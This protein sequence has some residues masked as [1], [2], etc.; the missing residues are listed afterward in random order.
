M[1]VCYFAVHKFM[2]LQEMRKSKEMKKLTDREK[3]CM[4]KKKNRVSLSLLCCYLLILLA[5]SLSTVVI[6]NMARN[7]MIDNQKERITS[8]LSQVNNSFNQE[9]KMAQNVGYYVSREKRLVNYLS[10]MKGKNDAQ[11]FYE[12]YTIA[13][14]YPNYSL[15]NQT[16][17]NVY[18]LIADSDYIIRIPQVLPKNEHGAATLEGFP[19]YSYERFQEFYKEQDKNQTLF[20]YEENP[21]QGSLLLP[22]QMVYPGIRDRECAIV[23]E[24]DWSKIVKMMQPVLGG[25]TGMVALLDREG[26]VLESCQIRKNSSQENTL[27]NQNF[28]T[29]RNT[30]DGDKVT[31]FQINCGY[32]GWQLAAAIPNEVLYQR[33]GI[34]RYVSIALCVTAILIGVLICFGYWYRGKGVVE[35]CYSLQER[36]T[37]NVIGGTGFWKNFGIF[38]NQVDH[39]HNTVEKQEQMLK[40]AVLRKVLY[41][42]YKSEEEILESAV[43]VQF[44]LDDKNYSVVTIELEDP[45]QA[46]SDIRINRDTLQE[47]INEMIRNTLPWNIWI[48]RVSELSSVLLVHEKT[49]I[50]REELKNDLNKLNFELHSRLNAKGYIGVSGIAEEIADIPKQYEIASRVCEYARYQGIC[51]PVLPEDMPNEKIIEQPMFFSIDM[52]MKLI[53]LLKSGNV[54]QIEEMIAQI[55]EIYLYQGIDSYIYRHTVEMLRGCLFRSIPTENES[56]KSRELSAAASKAHSAGEIFAMMRKVGAF[57]EEAAKERDESQVCIDK[58]KVSDYIEENYGDPT[59]NLSVLAEWLGEPERRIYND[60]KVCFGMS[61]SSYLEQRRLASACELLKKGAAVKDIAE[62]VGYSSDYSFR[63]AFKRAFGVSPSDFKKCHPTS[64]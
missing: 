36:I 55:K 19:L 23:V 41:G 35:E 14:N 21:G 10:Q 31:Y 44:P 58:Q 29:L 37:Q 64:V 51:V 30:K 52:E 12:Q 13:G 46:E 56:P 4:N 62:Q 25:N 27:V 32:N 33:I 63:R 3:K 47:A 59:L 50:N 61:F 45:F 18:I 20:Y 22:C 2:V 60:F 11:Q 15:T 57:W 42:N 17:K 1:K 28:N 40:Q 9:I 54:Q 48:Y 24:L 8:T 34:I 16:I 7:S 38:L 6:Y 26:N 53:S 49:D 43:A 39:L 5:P